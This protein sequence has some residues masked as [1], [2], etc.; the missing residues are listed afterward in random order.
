MPEWCEGKDWTKKVSWVENE[1]TRGSR[2][3]LQA[4]I[5]EP[6]AIV[7]C[8]G[9][10]GF[11]RQ[12]LL[13]GNEVANVEATAAGKVVGAERIAYVSVSSEVSASE[14]W[15]PGFFGAYFDGKRSAEEAMTAEFGENACTIKP[16]FIYGGDNFG[17]F[18]PRVS[19]WYGA[20]I[21]ELLS[22][23]VGS[24]GM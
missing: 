5:G 16:S 20:F 18:P 17:L 23:Y 15:L 8:I 3:K 6:D 12:G 7:S 9:A 19:G 10:V 1:L 11:D 2:Q 13:L 22:H 21:E 14:G 4:A 24:N